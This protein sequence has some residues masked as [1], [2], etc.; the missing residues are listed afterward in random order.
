M[1]IKVRWRSLKLVVSIL[2]HICMLHEDMVA[3]L[4]AASGTTI[5][6]VCTF[7]VSF[8]LSFYM[9]VSYQCLLD[10]WTPHFEQG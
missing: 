1:G 5:Y 10:R 7:E 2:V 9:Y 6:S 4:G 3:W 8:T